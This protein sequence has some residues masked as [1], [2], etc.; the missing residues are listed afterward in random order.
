MSKK[1]IIE[2]GTFIYGDVDYH[3]QLATDRS[4]VQG[5][6][7]WILD[8][9][10]KKFH[11]Y[12]RSTEFGGFSKLDIEKI[13]KTGNYPNE[14]REYKWIISEENDPLITFNMDL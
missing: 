7:L 2:N 9:T 8:Q 13:L 1:F 11:L 4:K 14:L 3:Y 5:G 12:G 10:N 6:G